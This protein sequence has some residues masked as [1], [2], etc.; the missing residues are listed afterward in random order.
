MTLY[1]VT[2]CR[3]GYGTS[4]VAFPALRVSP[5][6]HTLLLGP[7]GSGKTTLLHLFAGLIV[8]KAGE[9]RFGD[10]SLGSLSESQ[11]DA[12][13]GSH[14]GL[15][16]QRTH[17]IDALDVADNLLLALRI[18]NKVVDRAKAIVLLSALGLE[19][20][21]TKRPDELSQGEQQRVAIARA[22]IHA[23][24]VILADEPTSALDD[25]NCDA[26]MNLLVGQANQ[27]NATLIVATHD[28]RIRSRFAQVV[29]LPPRTA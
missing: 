5:G 24:S 14:I 15:V 12:W 23:P 3:A 8:P 20:M 25:A 10:L 2:D 7:S 17:L 11:R 18:A 26:A 22:S 16:M 1:A 19:A 28:A 27:A 13:R 4:D 6:R 21:A 29:E 9:V